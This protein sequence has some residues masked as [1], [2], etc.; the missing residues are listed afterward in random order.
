MG[1]IVLIGVALITVI[2]CKYIHKLLKKDIDEK[3]TDQKRS[4]TEKRTDMVKSLF[5]VS[6]LSVGI[7]YIIL[8]IQIYTH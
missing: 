5:W 3:L 2:S 1:T 6:I 7:I 4:N 8:N